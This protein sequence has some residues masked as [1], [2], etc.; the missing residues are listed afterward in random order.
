MIWWMRRC[1]SEKYIYLIGWIEYLKV[2]WGKKHLYGVNDVP[3]S[4]QI[5]GSSTW[6]I[7]ILKP[8]QEEY[9]IPA[10]HARSVREGLACRGAIVVHTCPF[11]AIVA[12]LA[13]R[14]ANGHSCLLLAHSWPAASL[15]STA[16]R[17]MASLEK[18]LASRRA[19]LNFCAH[20]WTPF[21]AYR[22]WTPLTG[23]S[24]T[25]GNFNGMRFLLHFIWVDICLLF[26]TFFLIFSCKSGDNSQGVHNM[27]ALCDLLPVTSHDL[28]IAMSS[29]R[30][31]AWIQAA[32]TST[33]SR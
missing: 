8:Y 6:L 12:I 14:V 29:G 2:G 21:P 4:H 10:Q 18:P 23:H 3:R 7:L 25:K 27:T 20:D 28:L 15:S 33:D 17:C 22:L 31:R 11:L 24:W 9:P 16:R 32:S 13:S 26:K 1:G 19:R 30:A 5:S